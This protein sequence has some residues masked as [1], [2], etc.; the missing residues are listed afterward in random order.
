[1]RLECNVDSFHE[2]NHGSDFA[3][4]ITVN[5][6]GEEGLFVRI[7]AEGAQADL[8][9]GMIAA[10]KV[11]VTLSAVKCPATVDDAAETPLRRWLEQLDE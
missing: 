2:T 6:T 4:K 3:R 1:M 11:V 9:A 5:C 8:L 7:W 10:G